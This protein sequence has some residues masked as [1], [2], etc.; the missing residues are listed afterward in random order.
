MMNW[1]DRRLQSK[2]SHH[3][4]PWW[5]P[6][7]VFHGVSL[8]DY[9]RMSKFEQFAWTWRFKNEL[10]GSTEQLGVPYLRVKTEEI[11]TDPNALAQ[12]ASFIGMGS[13]ELIAPS[14][15]TNAS[16]K[17][18]FPTWRNWTKEQRQIVKRHCGELMEDYGYG[19][20]SEWLAQ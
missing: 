2:I 5:S 15:Q 20:E 14:E 10:F 16:A 17:R 9:L 18:T 13:S 6:S 8:A 11:T 4:I 12:I 19:Y 1:K 3:V 7:P